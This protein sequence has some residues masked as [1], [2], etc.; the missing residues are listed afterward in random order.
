VLV[1]RK[2]AQSLTRYF[3]ARNFLVDAEPLRKLPQ[4]IP[5]R[6]QERAWQE[7]LQEQKGRSAKAPNGNLPKLTLTALGVVF[8]DIGTSPLYAIRECFHPAHQLALNAVNIYGI[9][10]LV[11]WALMLVVTFKYLFFILRADNRSEGG[12][13][14]MLSL[15]Q[16]KR[17]KVPGYSSSGWKK[18]TPILLG[19]LGAA[20]VYGDGVITPAISVLSAIEGLNIATPFLAPAVVPLT[21]VVL[22]VLFAV[23]SRGTT[24]I[25]S[26]FGP[27]T[28]VWFLTIGAIGVPWIFRNPEILLAINPIYAVRFFSANGFAGFFVLS[29]VILCV[30]GAEAL[31]ADM[32]H[33]GKKPIRIGWLALVFPA[34]LLNYFGQGAL[35]LEKGQAALQ[36]PF[37]GLVSGWMLL[38]LVGIATVATI[39]AS[40]AMISGAYSLTQ[41]AIQLGYLPRTHIDHTSSETVGQIYI[42][43]VNRF[44]MI[45]SIG[46]VLLFSNSSNLAAAYGIAVTGTMVVT[47]V[48]FFL[49]ARQVWSWKLLPAAALLGVFL[50]VDVAFF[51]A[52]LSK[53][54]H[55][56]WVVILIAA[57]VFTVMTTW[58]KGREVLA[59]V[60]STRSM[61]LERFIAMI[62]R[63]RPPRVK[64][65]AV[66]MSLTEGIAPPVLLHH[67]RH[68][69]VLHERVIVLTIATRNEPLVDANE[70]VTV[71]EF[72]HGFVK[73]KA[74]YGYMENPDISEIL[75]FCLGT[76]LELDITELSFYLGRESFLT[77]GD[78]RMASWRKKLFVLLSRNARPATDY[79]GLPPD[80]VVELG[81][82]VVI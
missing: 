20:L 69:R 68:N 67:F 2:I 49:V 82:Q 14:A 62:P 56:G 17:R 45:G 31:Y 28:L 52:N 39:I 48:L 76:G 21:V 81:A 38:P 1:I 51:T 58:K 78:S 63:K 41:Q 27:A 55:G 42:G 64:G 9:L 60:M 15:L 13:M 66:F 5:P 77:T 22:L 59:G 54:V 47:S 50:F 44:L 7:P 26:I 33:F 34:L 43:Q 65:T 3:G 71:K 72:P 40:Q 80:Q 16:S 46:L 11:F 37:Y 74:R 36:N 25:G 23:Q 61:P 6:D 4:N 32:G 53:V 24:H 10:S 73:V 30:T 57:V 18:T 35:L 75:I 29:A 70:R 12:T 8:G 79:F 19:L